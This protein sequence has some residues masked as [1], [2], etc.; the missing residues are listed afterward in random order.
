M[1]VVESVE[2]YLS[3]AD[4]YERVQRAVRG[5]AGDDDARTPAALESVT[6][7]YVDAAP[8]GSAIESAYTLYSY[9]P[10]L[11][12]V[13]GCVLLARALVLVLVRW[14]RDTALERPAPVAIDRRTLRTL[15]KSRT[16]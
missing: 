8:L 6:I 1:S 15:V 3:A 13:L 2:P 7:K 11:L 5:L 12:T 4:E 16:Q 9:T 10:T 14:R